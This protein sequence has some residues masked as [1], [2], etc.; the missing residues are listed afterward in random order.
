MLRKLGTRA[1]LLAAL[2]IA[3]GHAATAYDG[4]WCAHYFGTDY[5]TNCSMLSFA[6]CR[7]ETHGIGG[8]FC[9]PNPAYH[10]VQR[11]PA[12]GAQHRPRRVL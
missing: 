10:P 1:A 5:T 4:P 3:G 12:E 6:M 9:S 8:T 2:L 11:A 7:R